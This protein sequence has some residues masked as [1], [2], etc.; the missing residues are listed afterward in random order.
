V[1][2]ELKWREDHGGASIERDGRFVGTLGPE[3]WWTEPKGEAQVAWVAAFLE[4]GVEVMVRVAVEV[5]I[6]EVDEGREEE[7]LERRGRR[8]PTGRRRYP[9]RP[10]RPRTRSRAPKRSTGISS[11]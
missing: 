1:E 10:A 11:G 2:I 4:P 8:S 3:A 6:G 9:G 5:P 7:M